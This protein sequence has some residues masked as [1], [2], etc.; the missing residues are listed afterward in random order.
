MNGNG[1]LTVI[2]GPM[3]SGK[4]TELVREIN[5]HIFAHEPYVAFKPD[6]DNRYAEDFIVT[7]PTPNNDGI[8]KLPAFSIP[9]NDSCRGIILE[10]SAD[11]RVIGFDEVQFWNPSVKLPELIRD[12]VEKKDKIVYATTLNMSYEGKGFKSAVNLVLYA[13]EIRLLTSVCAKCGNKAIYS[14]RVDPS[15]NPVFRGEL[16]QVGNNYQARCGKCFEREEVSGLIR[17]AEP[18]LVRQKLTSR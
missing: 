16:I 18:D 12:L 15:G 14:Q 7:H 3:F 17:T 10:K 13:N 4:S 1:W 9:V 8:M 2:T 6:I 5:R 11:A